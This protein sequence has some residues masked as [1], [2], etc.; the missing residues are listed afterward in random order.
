MFLNESFLPGLEN[1]AIPEKTAAPANAVVLI[2]S[3]RFNIIL[4]RN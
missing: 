4:S 3:L 1:G 2:K